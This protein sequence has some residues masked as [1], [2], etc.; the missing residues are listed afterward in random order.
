MKSMP[1]QVK[2]MFFFSIMILI[3]G[4][5]NMPIVYN[6]M[7]GSNEAVAL[8]RVGLIVFAYLVYLI[9]YI[10]L[11]FRFFFPVMA[12]TAF[13]CIGFF[14]TFFDFSIL[15]LSQTLLQFLSIML[16]YMPQTRLWLK[17]NS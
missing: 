8:T 16:F 4:I 13:Y 10:F 2:L 12:L 9:L 11:F 7:S 14:V 3:I 15:N 6:N 17:R 1:N 5:I